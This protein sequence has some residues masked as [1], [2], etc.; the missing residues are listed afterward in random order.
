M[1][2]KDI[3]RCVIQLNL[4]PY[5]FMNWS[6]TVESIPPIIDKDRDITRLIMNLSRESM[7]IK[8]EGRGSINHFIL[9]KDGDR[10][11]EVLKEL[12]ENGNITIEFDISQINLREYSDEMKKKFRE[13]DH[14]LY[15]DIIWT[16]GDKYYQ[17]GFGGI[18]DYYKIDSYK[19]DGKSR[20]ILTIKTLI[21][22]LLDVSEG[23]IEM[24]EPDDKD[25]MIRSRFETVNDKIVRIDMVDVGEDCE[26]GCFSLD[27]DFTFKDAMDLMVKLEKGEKEDG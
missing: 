6:Y 26:L 17:R 18:Y 24:G 23:I 11:R 12:R 25:S 20:D 14:F 3:D 22:E 5:E 9:H 21:L 27:D 10:T 2:N 15:I 16:D 13:Y 1:T 19:I 8:H 7:M 4:F